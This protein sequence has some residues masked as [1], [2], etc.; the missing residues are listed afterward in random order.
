MLHSEIRRDPAERLVAERP[1]SFAR[2]PR[3]VRPSRPGSARKVDRLADG[4]LGLGP[5]LGAGH[6]PGRRV[7]VLVGGRGRADRDPP[8]GPARSPAIRLVAPG[9]G[10]RSRD[11]HY[12]GPRPGPARAP[13]PRTSRRAGLLRARRAGRALPASPRRRPARRGCRPRS[14]RSS[15]W[16]PP[17]PRCWLVG[18]SAARSALP[19]LPRRRRARDP[20]RGAGGGSTLASA[21]TPLGSSC[22]RCRARPLSGLRPL[23]PPDDRRRR[24]ALRRIS[25]LASSA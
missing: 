23:E 25:S 22:P 4:A 13:R 18:R 5:L 2:C 9:R 1:S 16:R 17:G 7:Q 6:A 14:P 11:E 12:G 20:S 3:C 24:A 15:A 19:P 10:G 21:G 8:P